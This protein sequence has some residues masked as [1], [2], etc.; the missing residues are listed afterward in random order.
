M[1]KIELGKCPYCKS[2]D[3]YPTNDEWVIEMPNNYIVY[4]CRCNACGEYFSE[5]YSQDE[6]KFD[7][8]EEEFIYNNTLGQ[9]DKDTIKG[10]AEAELEMKEEQFTNKEHHDDYKMRVKRIIN[11]MSGGLEKE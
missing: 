9:E 10:W 2:T 11:L 1:K 8:D 4:S 6:I 3:Y 5:Y 7:N